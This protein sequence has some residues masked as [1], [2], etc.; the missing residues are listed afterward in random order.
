VAYSEV[1]PR[2]LP[3]VR[4]ENEENVADRIVRVPAE[5]RTGNNLNGKSEASQLEP[6]HWVRCSVR[7]ADSVGQ[8]ALQSATGLW[9]GTPFGT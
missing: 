2:Y 4:E 7:S 1:L 3:G 6:P 8:T 9:W 5:I